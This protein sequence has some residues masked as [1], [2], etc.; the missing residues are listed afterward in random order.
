MASKQGYELIPCIYKSDQ[1]YTIARELLESFLEYYHME[2]NKVEELRKAGKIKPGIGFWFASD[3]RE[4]VDQLLSSYAPLFKH[5]SMEI[6]DERRLVRTLN[7]EN[8]PKVMF[9]K[10]IRGVTPYIHFD[11]IS[12]A[13]LYP[14]DIDNMH[15]RFEVRLCPSG[16]D[17]ELRRSAIDM[18]F[19]EYEPI[20][21]S[22]YDTTY[23]S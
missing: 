5:P 12:S 4:F 16:T 21:V 11:L 9:R 8:P 14:N 23:K 10:G 1:Q 20:N 15:N 19:S 13:Q 7:A 17:N 18:M 2:H 3:V 22:Y 6:E